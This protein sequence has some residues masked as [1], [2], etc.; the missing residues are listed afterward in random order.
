MQSLKLRYSSWDDQTITFEL[1]EGN[2]TIGRSPGNDF[3]IDEFSVSEQ[4]C[5]V[6]IDDSGAQIK[7]LGSIHGTYLDG[8]P[9]ESSSHFSDGQVINLGTLMIKVLPG[10]GD[11]SGESSGKLES[12]L[13]SDGSYS[14]LAHQAQRA[15]FECEHCHHLYCEQCLP[16]KQGSPDEQIRCPKCGRPGKKIDWSGLKMTS[17]DAAYELMPD[18]MKEAWSYYKKWKDIR[19]KK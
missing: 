11:K 7:D 19:K 13:L 14:C 1:G 18:S 6:S 3:V 4:H 12:V 15:S 2:Y 10:D 9:L 16:G 5:Q 8:I 17:R